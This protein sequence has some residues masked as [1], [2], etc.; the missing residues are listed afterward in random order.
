MHS[1]FNHL[2]KRSHK[3]LL[4]LVSVGLL[5]LSTKPVF[6]AVEQNVEAQTNLANDAAFL[7]NNLQ[8]QQILPW[9][10]DRIIQIDS[11]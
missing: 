7:P 8:Q 1:A 3:L 11:P 2:F 10:W 6:N 9:D 5:H 4:P